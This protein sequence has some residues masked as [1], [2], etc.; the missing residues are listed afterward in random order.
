MNRLQLAAWLAVAALL[1]GGCN[2]LGT[3]GDE[4]GNP[5]DPTT[6][7]GSSFLGTWQSSSTG[8]PS[9]D[10]CTNVVW[11]L[12]GVDGSTVFGSFTATCAGGFDVVGTGSGTPSGAMLN[13]TAIGTASQSGAS[14]PFSL[15]GTATPV[16]ESVLQ[17]DYTGTVCG[18]PVQGSEQLDRS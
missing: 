7:D 8:L 3:S 18:I 9:L 5:I 1:S 12:T 10:S 4:G 2:L 14:C 16:G 17:I 15:S 11:Q 13:W 6:A